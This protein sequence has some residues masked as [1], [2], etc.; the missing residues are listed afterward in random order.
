MK[1]AIVCSANGP[2]AEAVKL[3]F[4]DWQIGVR[5]VS[6]TAELIE[7]LEA[8]PSLIAIQWAG[9]GF[10]AV[11]K[12]RALR[13][14]YI[15]SLV[16]AIMPPLGGSSPLHRAM[17][18]NAGADDAQNW[19]I[20]GNEFVERFRAICRRTRPAEEGPVVFGTN[21]EFYPS[22]GLIRGPG[23]EC[24]LPRREAQLLA[25]LAT[26]PDAVVPF[27]VIMREMYGTTGQPGGDIIKVMAAKVRRKLDVIGGGLEFVDSHWGRGYRF[28]PEGFEV[29]RH[30]NGARRAG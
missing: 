14:R 24:Q 2:F 13:D 28:V 17:A 6:S 22:S 27:E 8:K 12:I 26:R 10:D 5:V 23:V 19:P 15:Q 7:A 1:E 4:R 30:A 20:E 25:C 16:F 29:A 11:Y 9:D 21:L 3:Y 18:L